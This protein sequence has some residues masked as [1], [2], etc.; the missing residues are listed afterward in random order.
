MTALRHIV[1]IFVLPTAVTV[2]G[3]YLI[4]LPDPSRSFAWT[5]AGPI[6]TIFAAA[7]FGVLAA[8]LT[9]LC[10]TIWQFAKIGR[11]TLAPWDPPKRFVAAGVYRYV[12]NPMIS[13]VLLILLGETILFRSVGLLVWL[14]G[15]FAVNAT[16]I[17]LVEE[18]GLER[19]FGDR[20]REYKLHVPRWIP[21]MSPWEAPHQNSR[22]RNRS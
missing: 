4:L 19:R 14:A 8:G 2:V 17:P 20:Y 5:D 21:R 15:F 10:S 12:R 16:Y 3:P 7:G 18:P 1:A 11:G 6:R 13:G 9:L 22:G